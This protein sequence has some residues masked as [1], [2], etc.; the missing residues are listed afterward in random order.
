MLTLAIALKFDFRVF[1]GILTDSG[2]SMQKC[3]LIRVN[4]VEKNWKS[5]KKSKNPNH[6]VHTIIVPK[7]EPRTPSEPGKNITKR[8]FGFFY[9][10]KKTKT[11]MDRV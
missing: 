9:G 6:M 7:D 10:K 1:L 3:S 4:F 8:I 5:R 11:V 2:H